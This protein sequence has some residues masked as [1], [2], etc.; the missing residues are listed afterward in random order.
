VTV[1]PARPPS[2]VDTILN[3][4][5]INDAADESEK[6]YCVYVAVGQ[7][8]STVAQFVKV[9]EERGALDYTIVVAATASDPAPMQFSHRSPAAPWA[10]ISATTACTP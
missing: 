3:Q 6:L 10:N 9:L 4:K 7:K 2:C 5:A 1:R 8:R